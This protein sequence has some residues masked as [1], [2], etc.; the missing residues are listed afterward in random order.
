MPN[1]A[2]ALKQEIARIARK[3]MR[4]ELDSLRKAVSTQRT[5][6]ARIKRECAG[7]GQEVRRLQREL[8]RFTPTPTAAAE[9]PTATFRYSAE[10]L[11]SARAKLGLSAADFGRLV[12]A[13][14]LSIYKW[15]RGTKPRE[16]FMPALARAVTMGKREAS[17]QLQQSGPS[18]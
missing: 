18:P 9:E 3:E 6:L 16:K 15:E 14:A 8:G 4:S 17:A 10:R 7:L 13:S 2:T 5:D 1:L 11:A 12:G